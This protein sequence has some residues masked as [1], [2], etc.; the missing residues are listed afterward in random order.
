MPSLC[1]FDL[2]GATE[3]ALIGLD[4]TYRLKDFFWVDEARLIFRFGMF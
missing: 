3:S 1:V 4:S 2:T